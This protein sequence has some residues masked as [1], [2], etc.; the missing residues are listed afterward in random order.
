MR[1]DAALRHEYDRCK[2]EAASLGPD[3]YWAAKN[4]FLTEIRG[5]IARSRSAQ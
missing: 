4:A 3:G 5:Q 1:T 2:R